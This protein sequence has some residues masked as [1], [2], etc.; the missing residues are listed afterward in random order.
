LASGDRARVLG[1]LVWLGGYHCTIHEGEPAHASH[2]TAAEANLVRAVRTRLGVVARL[3]ELGESEDEW[4]SEAARQ[5]AAP[6]D[7]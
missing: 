7:L 2:E 4:V 5:A 1:A 6:E 3:R